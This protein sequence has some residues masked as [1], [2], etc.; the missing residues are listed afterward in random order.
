VRIKDDLEK[1]IEELEKIKVKYD[2]IKAPGASQFNPGWHE[3]LSLRNL[4]ITT[5]AVARA[6]LM[7]EESRG[8]HSRVDFPGESAE[9]FKYN[10]VLS[11]DADGNM[12]VR[13]VE[14]PE[15]DAELKRIGESGLEELEKEVA[16]DQANGK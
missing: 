7:R 10:I 2:N 9:W 15:P 6:A 3:A 4:L 1:G 11:K 12:D 14:R 5:E 8:A 16:E 13:K